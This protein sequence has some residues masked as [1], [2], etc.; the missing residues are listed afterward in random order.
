MCTREHGSV[1]R[2]TQAL[3]RRHEQL[4]AEGASFSIDISYQSLRDHEQELLQEVAEGTGGKGEG[5]EVRGGGRGA[6][7]T[8]GAKAGV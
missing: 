1:P 2:E 3:L 8:G 4:L 6:L 7:R 5:I